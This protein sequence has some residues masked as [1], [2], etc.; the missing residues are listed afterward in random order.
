MNE[1]N[2]KKIEFKK[3]ISFPCSYLAGKTEKRLYVNLNKNENNKLLISELTKNGF[4]RSHEHMYIPV[5][6]GC[7]ACIPSRINTKDFKFSKSNSKS[8]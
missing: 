6:E 8:Y 4:R 7:N 1:F 2:E 3:S 5:C